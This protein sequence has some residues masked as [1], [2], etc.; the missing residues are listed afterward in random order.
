MYG[1]VRLGIDVLRVGVVLLDWFPAC[2]LPFGD[3]QFK[4]WFD[5]FVAFRIQSC[6]SKW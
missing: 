6:V 3:N 5:F 2:I 1:R 4:S